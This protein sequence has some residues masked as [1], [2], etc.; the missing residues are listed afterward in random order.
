MGFGQHGQQGMMT[1]ASVF[2]RIVAFQRA[3]L[4][5]IAFEDSGIQVQ[6]VTAAAL[7]SPQNQ[8][9]L[10]YIQESAVRIPSLLKKLELCVGLALLFLGLPLRLPRHHQR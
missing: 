7:R 1:G 5:A 8:V 2:A 9:Y 6:A 3:L 10:V 4:V